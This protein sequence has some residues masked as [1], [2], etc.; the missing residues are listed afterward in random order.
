MPLGDLELLRA[1]MI[2]K[3]KCPAECALK[4][5]DFLR[6]PNKPFEWTGHHHL[7]ASPP[8]ALCL[9]LKGSVLRTERQQIKML[10]GQINRRHSGL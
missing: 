8:R 6:D 7:S 5:L 9:P 2:M 3:I 1:K 4:I 10:I